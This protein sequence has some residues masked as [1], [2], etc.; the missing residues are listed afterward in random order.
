MFVIVLWLLLLF[1][2]L[3]V[4]WKELGLSGVY[5]AHVLAIIVANMGVEEHEDSLIPQI[6]LAEFVFFEAVDLWISEH[7]IDTLEVDDH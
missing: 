7:I 6:S 1:E 2:Q 3:E 5:Q 4:L